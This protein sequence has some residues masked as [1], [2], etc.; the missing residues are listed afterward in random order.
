MESFFKFHISKIVEL[1]KNL[2]FEN[3]AYYVDFLSQQFHLIQNSTRY[4]ALAAANTPVECHDDFNR[5]AHHLSEELDHDKGILLDLKKLGI[6]QPLPALTETKAMINNQYYAIEK[7]G[8]DSLFGYALMLEGLSLQCC[9]PINTRVKSAHGY[10][11][12]YLKMHSTADE[13][14]FP[15]GIKYIETIS[16]SRKEI[17]KENVEIMSQLYMY[18]LIATDNKHKKA[19]HKAS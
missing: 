1:T 4:I 3:K 9:G 11:S 16:S 6:L 17:I 2:D 18:L 7:K 5:W 15:A 12:T 13:K 19:L 14:H 10:E 8:A